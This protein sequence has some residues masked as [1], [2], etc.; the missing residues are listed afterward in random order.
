MENAPDKKQAKTTNR[1]N[2]DET[3]AAA[4]AIIDADIAARQ[5]KTARLKALRL[6]QQQVE[7][8]TAKKAPRKSSRPRPPA[9]AS[10]K[11]P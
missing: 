9:G 1:R 10:A 2:A 3:T 6:E 7:V 5:R 11:T 4:L 8:T